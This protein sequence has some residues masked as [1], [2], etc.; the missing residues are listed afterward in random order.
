MLLDVIGILLRGIG[1]VTIG[2]RGF[3]PAYRSGGDSSR[4][5]FGYRGAKARIGRAVAGP[6]PGRTVSIEAPWRPAGIWPGTKET[7]AAA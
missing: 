6:K 2:R 1:V 7:R 5:V 3:A 4:R